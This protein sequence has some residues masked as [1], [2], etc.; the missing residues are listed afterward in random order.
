MQGAC[1][2][3]LSQFRHLSFAQR[4]S[5]PRRK[6]PQISRI[7]RALA[8]YTET[9]AAVCAIM[10][11]LWTPWRFA[12]VTSADGAPRPGI[13][14]RLKAFPGDTGCVFCNL[15]GSIDYA[16]EHGMS[17]RRGGSGRRAGF[18]R[19]NLLYLPEC[20]SLHVGTRDGDALCAPGPDREAVHGSGPRDDGPGAADGARAGEA[21]SAAWVQLRPEPGPG[22]GGRR[23]RAPA[24]ARHAAL[25]GRYQFHDHGGG[26]AG[27]AG[28]SG[29]DVE[30]A[31]E[32]FELVSDSVSGQ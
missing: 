6:S 5:E 9:R 13:P 7:P 4:S 10:D 25:G 26:N 22:G 16:I 31:R 29:N 28:R 18:P 14:A 15:I 19:H 8:T 27:A 30:E 20:V 2:S 23:G 21:V 11:I 17:R 32:R 24:H 1:S 12:Y 3:S